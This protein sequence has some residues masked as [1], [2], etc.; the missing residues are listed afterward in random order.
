MLQESQKTDEIAA[1]NKSKR[2]SIAQTSPEFPPGFI[3]ESTLGGEALYW[4][5]VLGAQ[6]F[7][8][9]PK[10]KSTVRSLSMGE[11]VSL[12]LD[13]QVMYYHLTKKGQKRPLQQHVLTPFAN[14]ARCRMKHGTFKR[15]SGRSNK[16]VGNG[17]GRPRWALA[18]MN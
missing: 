3:Q 11:T 18:S 15:M 7:W 10:N 12:S 16:Q 2:A 4:G 6:T 14:G 8:D 9:C 5:Y 13:T 1:E 17:Q